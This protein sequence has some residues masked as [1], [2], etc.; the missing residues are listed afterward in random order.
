MGCGP[1]EERVLLTGL[2]AVAD[3]YCE[4]CKTTLG[5]KYVSIST[6]WFSWDC[7]PSSPLW[8]CACGVV[9]GNK[10]WLGN[11][12]CGSW[13][14]A[15][16]SR[17]FHIPVFTPVLCLFSPFR[18]W[19]LCGWCVALLRA[20]TAAWFWLV[21]LGDTQHKIQLVLWFVLSFFPDPLRIMEWSIQ[22]WSCVLPTGNA[23]EHDLICLLSLALYKFNYL[24]IKPCATFLFLLQEARSVLVCQ[25]ILSSI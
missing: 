12:K 18:A 17:P 8:R 24:Q 2:H 20:G 25:N 23:I 11:Q 15:T 9:L 6:V 21:S 5:W 10:R 13:C 14:A 16:S 3:I 7:L 1:A 22:R 19:A 4:N